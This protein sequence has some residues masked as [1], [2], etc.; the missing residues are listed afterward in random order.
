MM[1]SL[2]LRAMAF[3]SGIL[4]LGGTAGL[5]FGLCCSIVMRSS[6]ASFM[7]SQFTVYPPVFL[8]GLSIFFLL[9]AK[10]D[11]NPFSLHLGMVWPVEGMPPIIQLIAYCVPFTLP[12]KALRKLFIKDIIT[13]VTLRPVV[14]GYATLI[15]WCF[16]LLFLCLWLLRDK[17]R[18]QSKSKGSRLS[19]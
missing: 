12:I 17:S 7:V 16:F 10:L 13:P 18:R 15:A 4:F 3:A 2:C 1:P 9:I 5:L 19:L 8:S 11:P 14:L 6:F